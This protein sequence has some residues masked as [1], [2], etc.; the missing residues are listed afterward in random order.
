MTSSARSPLSA[1]PLRAS[2]SIEK[3]GTVG[4]LQRKRL[5]HPKCLQY[6]GGLTLAVVGEQDLSEPVDEQTSEIAG[7]GSFDEADGQA[8]VFCDLREA[9]QQDGLA[10]A[11]Q[12]DRYE[13]LA[14]RP[15]SARRTVV[16]KWSISWSRPRRAGGW[17]RHQGG[18]DWSAVHPNGPYRVLF[19]LWC[20]A[21]SSVELCLPGD[22]AAPATVR[23]PSNPEAE[24]TAAFPIT[25][26]EGVED[27][28]ARD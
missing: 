23:P 2:T 19:I 25:L 4:H 26:V 9:I 22:L 28:R 5:Q 8:F 10:H 7:L 16:A 14:G 20:Y 12:A 13:A 6:L 18:R 3:A 17:S 27:Q 1:S 24:P 21:I 11:P 15:A